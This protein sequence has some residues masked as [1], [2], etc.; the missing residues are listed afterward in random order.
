MLGANS[1]L[2]A[3]TTR[4]PGQPRRDLLAAVRGLHVRA[5]ALVIDLVRRRP[6][7]GLMQCRMKLT[8]EVQ[9]AHRRGA[10]VGRGG[11]RW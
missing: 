3:L 7:L 5:E 1:V 4:A 2:N 10:V 9:S 11:I 8:D 6:V